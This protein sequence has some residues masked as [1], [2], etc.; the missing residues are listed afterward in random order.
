MHANTEPIFINLEGAQEESISSL[1]GRYNTICCTG[2]PGYIGFSECIP[3]LLKRLQIRS[4]YQY[5]NRN[6]DYAI[7]CGA[8]LC[9]LCASVCGREIYQMTHAHAHCSAPHC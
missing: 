7:S 1:A 6:S 5:P 3:G 4:L 9:I 2:P 8:T